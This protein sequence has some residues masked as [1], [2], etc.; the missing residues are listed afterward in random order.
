MINASLQIREVIY[1]PIAANIRV[2]VYIIM[3]IT[4]DNNIPGKSK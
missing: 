2:E 4:N 3:T 1:S